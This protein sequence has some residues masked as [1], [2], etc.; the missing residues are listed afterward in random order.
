MKQSLRT[1]LIALMAS[2]TFATVQAKGTPMDVGFNELVKQLIDAGAVTGSNTET[3]GK[4]SFTQYQFKVARTDLKLITNYRDRVMRPNV[5]NAYRSVFRTAGTVGDSHGIGYGEDNSQTYYVCTY[6]DRNYAIIYLRDPSDANCRYVYTLT[7]WETKGKS[8]EGSI[9]KFYGLDPVVQRKAQGTRETRIVVSAAGDSLAV[10]S[11]G[12][13]RYY[14]LEV[15]KKKGV[16]KNSAEVLAEISKI[17]S[18]YANI[19]GEYGTASSHKMR[20]VY[21]RYR[22]VLANRLVSVCNLYGRTMLGINDRRA[23]LRL[24]KTA[25][26]MGGDQVTEALFISAKELLSF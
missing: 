17:C 24:I 16:P 14:N 26:D 2:L 8:I 5:A 10:D 22:L 13:M 3:Y 1:F 6:R 20:E 12:T 18:V 7:W 11:N 9:C 25:Q 23:A 4:G 21:S 15:F 19:S